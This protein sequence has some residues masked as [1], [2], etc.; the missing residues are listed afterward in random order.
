MIDA[1]VTG[2][3][4]HVKEIDNMIY[5]RIVI[6]GDTPVQFTARRGVV[7]AALLALPGGM[8]VAVSGQ[9]TSVV[10]FDTRGKS[11]VFHEILVTAVMTAQKPRGLLA[12]IL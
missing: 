8:P 7:K 6:D 2:R 3:L 10:K 12:S 4:I 11:Y 9:L 5:G 1:L